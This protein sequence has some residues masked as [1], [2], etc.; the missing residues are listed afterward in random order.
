MVCYS[1]ESENDLFLY[2]R[3]TGKRRHLPDISMKSRMFSASVSAM[4]LVDTLY[5]LGNWTRTS[6]AVNLHCT[7]NYFADPAKL[8]A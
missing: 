7:Q 4:T 3:R 5:D 1:N 6:R 8:I 2:R